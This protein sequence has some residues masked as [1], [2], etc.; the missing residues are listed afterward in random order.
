LPSRTRP[1]IKAAPRRPT[2]KRRTILVEAASASRQ[3]VTAL[4]QDMH[5]FDPYLH[6]ASRDDGDAY[7]NREAE[8]RTYIK[9]ANEFLHSLEDVML[10]IKGAVKGRRFPMI[11]IIQEKLRQYGATNAV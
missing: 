3:Q 10:A 7:R 5:R 8:R 1:S 6:F 11:E 9:A 2:P 4:M